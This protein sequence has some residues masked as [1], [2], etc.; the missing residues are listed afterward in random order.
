MATNKK[1]SVN[2]KILDEWR[3]AAKANREQ[4]L[5]TKYKI[6]DKDGF[7]RNFESNTSQR[8]IRFVIDEERK[9]W[10]SPRI[11]ILKSRQR[12]ISTGSCAFLFHDIYTGEN[13]S[14]VIM[15]HLESVTE[16][17]R[18]KLL[19][20]YDNLPDIAKM[21]FSSNSHDKMGWGHNNSIVRFGSAENPNFAIGRTVRQFL[22]S[23]H[24]RWPHFDTIYK[25]NLQG[26]PDSIYSWVILESTAKGTDHPS[27]DF[28]QECE[29][30]NE[31]FIPIFLKWWEDE[32]SIEPVFSSQQEQD[33]TMERVFYE[34]AEAKERMEY[35]L[36]G[37]AKLPYDEAV[38][39]IF[40]YYKRW[41]SCRRDMLKLQEN[42]PMTPEE[43]FIAS[44]NPFYP[45][46]VVSK[47]RLTCRE[48]DLIDP[49]IRFST[50]HNLVKAAGLERAKDTYLEIFEYPVP[51]EEYLVSADAAMGTAKGDY[52]CAIV[53]R[54]KTGDVVAVARGRLEIDPFSD[55]CIDLTELYNKCQLAPEAVGQG[56]SAL[57]ELL[58]YKKFSRFWRRRQ[59]TSKGWLPTPQLLYGWDTNT[60]TRPIMLEQSR[61]LMRERFNSGRYET[62]I[63]SAHLLA[64]M[65]TFVDVDGKPQ[66]KKGSH[67]DM[68]LAWNIGII[69]C[70]IE[71][72]VGALAT[73]LLAANHG[74]EKVIISD[75]VSIKQ[76]LKMVMN[77]N[78]TGQSFGE[79]YGG[80]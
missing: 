6:V 39:R 14:S 55:I 80:R 41:L 13:A 7:T 4:F 3:A 12:G 54:K 1:P 40:W 2:Y 37:Q 62:F 66:S 67:D 26:V 20:A 35:Y 24:T 47:L 29:K 56:G 58:K 31:L 75:A 42:F 9:A 21:P 59:F 50:I 27:Y 61:R 34:F 17:L 51:G 46:D 70:L 44:G 76:T 45:M 25:D 19:F 36:L 69:I 30:G 73:G 18:Q 74:T 63:P 28:W 49:L 15:T 64:E 71:S 57:M 10:R 22:G 68:V 5:R 79:Y 65:R 16:D 77:D 48:G 60:Q 78:W 52:S 32:D 11:N 23:E 72:N 43:A 33:E 38:R 8:L 53:F